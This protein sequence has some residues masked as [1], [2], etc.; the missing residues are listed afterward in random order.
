[1]KQQRSKPGS[2]DRPSAH[3]NSDR[4]VQSGLRSAATESEKNIYEVT[5]DFRKWVTGFPLERMDYL[6]LTLEIQGVIEG[7]VRGFRR[8]VVEGQPRYYKPWT[9][10]NSKWA[11]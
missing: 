2:S 11:G 4:G 9:P 7:V 6:E 8:A 3:S 10:K 1:V 5:K